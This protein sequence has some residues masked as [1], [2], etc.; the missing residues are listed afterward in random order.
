MQSPAPVFQPWNA[1]PAAGPAVAGSDSRRYAAR[2]LYSRPLD[3]DRSCFDRSLRGTPLQISQ[4]VAVDRRSH[5]HLP[6]PDPGLLD[7]T[8]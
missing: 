6:L 8:D 2:G 4:T 5:R 3:E 7:E 1:I